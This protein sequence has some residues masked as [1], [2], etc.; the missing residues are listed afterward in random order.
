MVGSSSRGLQHFMDSIGFVDLDFFGRNFTWTND[1]SRLVCI[2]ERL[3][4]SIANIAWHT[5]FPNAIVKHY[6][7]T[8]SDHVPLILNLF[9]CEISV[10]KTFKFE[11]LWAREDSYF[12]IITEA[13]RK[14]NRGKPCLDSFP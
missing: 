13:W 6:R 14:P 7:V 11:R 10:A 12:G 1:H 5:S 4:R 8:N 2:R 3:D 9:G